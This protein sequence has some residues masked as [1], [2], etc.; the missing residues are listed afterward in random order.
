MNWLL[1]GVLIFMLLCTLN[2]YRRGFI[3]L[4]VSLI[5]VVLTIFLVK[6]VTPY[7]S[8]FL[9]N[10][11]PL[12]DSIKENTMEIFREDAGEYNAEKKT[13]QVKAI[14]SS[15]L[16]ESLKEVLIENNNSEIYDI[17]EV[18]GFD[19]YIGTYV[20]KT[21]TNIIAFVLAFLIIF[22]FLKFIML[23]LD[24]VSRLP[25]LKGMNKTA[26]LFLGFAEGLMILWIA[27]L[28]LTVFCTGE[29]GA[30][31][32]EMIDDSFILSFLYSHN[33]LLNI[34]SA[35]VIGV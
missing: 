23:S 3:R 32:F 33:F 30:V 4:A 9:Q 26:G 22:I 18:T 15:R 24:L 34:I 11:T 20:A 10:H 6:T 1:I 29:K 25:L 19:D 7:F 35:L 8:D 13:D 5:F 2:G 17:L 27:A 21:L 16:P 31:I 12:Y 28:V 14:E